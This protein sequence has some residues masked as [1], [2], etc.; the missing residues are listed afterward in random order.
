M[1]AFNEASVI[2][3]KLRNACTEI[4]SADD[5]DVC[6]LGSLVLGDGKRVGL[7]EK[8]VT[9]GRLAGRLAMSKSGLIG[10]FGDKEAMQ[11]FW[12]VLMGTTEEMVDRVQSVNPLLG[13]GDMAALM[14][15]RP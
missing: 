9:I 8:S 10:R 4:T 13:G 2:A 14:R 3:E 6:N 11:R 7:G 15:D 1:S 5:S 12:G